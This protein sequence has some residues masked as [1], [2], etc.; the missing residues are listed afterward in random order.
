MRAPAFAGDAGGTQR[1][2]WGLGASGGRWEGRAARRGGG[3][4]REVQK[5]APLDHAF[6]GVQKAGGNKLKTTLNVC[7]SY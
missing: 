6:E 4:G 2:E 3:V 7:I 5:R 1:E